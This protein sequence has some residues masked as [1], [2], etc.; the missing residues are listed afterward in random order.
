MDRLEELL[1]QWQEGDITPGEQTE[2]AEMLK[3]RSARRAL[4][5]FA[6][7]ESD[8]REAL[9]ETEAEAAEE[10][11]RQAPEH[12]RPSPVGTAEPVR[13]VGRVRRVLSWAWR[14]AAVPLAAA[15]AILM[16]FYIAG[17]P[18]GEEEADAD[19]AAVPEFL[20]GPETP[21]LTEKLEGTSAGEDRGAAAAARKGTGGD[22]GPRQ[23]GEPRRSAAEAL[24]AGRPARLEDAERPATGA[25]EGRVPSPP[26]TLGYVDDFEGEVEC[27]R[28][29]DEVWL[30]SAAG[31]PLREGD[32]LRTKFSRARVAFESGSVLFLN[33]FTTLTLG[34]KA[35]RPGLSMVGG[36]VYVETSPR[37]SG[38]TV[39]TPHG[40]A[41]DLGTRFDVEVDR[42]GTTV[43]V[44][45][46]RVRAST[47]VGADE[48][49]PGREV[50][51]SR[52]KSPP[53]PVRRTADLRRRL[54]WADGLRGL[55][56]GA[57]RVRTGLVALYLFGE[58]R[59]SIVHD[60][61]RAG[62]PLNLHTRAGSA[63][64]WTPPGGLAIEEATAIVS[65]R[66]ADKIL[67]TCRESN[68]FTVEAWIR[69]AGREAT[70]V[71]IGS[72]PCFRLDEQ[73]DRFV[74]HVLVGKKKKQ[75]LVSPPGTV[76]RRLTQVVFTRAPEGLGVLYVNGMAVASGSAPGDLSAWREDSHLILANKDVGANATTW[77]GEF[78]L[79]AI[80]CRALTAREVQRN[81]RAIAGPEGRYL[82]WIEQPGT[83]AAP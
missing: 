49:A 62:R 61:S 29:A 40:R 32:G 52:R 69:P 43:L 50:L 57:R 27:R 42:T 18:E 24:S 41:V 65:N 17:L 63:I 78:R 14:N 2:L 45:E 35:G 56:G 7:A 67:E 21:G 77:P 30:S 4:Y 60:V 82:K 38:F 70:V 73:G 8:I 34:R 44:V 10:L 58:D 16:A 79:L 12:G 75:Q 26:K 11:L 81:Y 13:P 5:E 76:G 80:Y 68:E 19:H 1:F 46:G 25:R 37:D 22:T 36:E 54:A 33:R 6:R 72:R 28:R 20:P 66:P 31:T 83:Q 53:G 9:H 3:A 23:P 71:S 48:V 64:R 39:E 51:L 74:C 15:A 47:D 55:A 59:G